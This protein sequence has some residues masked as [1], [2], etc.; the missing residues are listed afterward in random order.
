MT[1]VQTCALPIS[2]VVACLKRVLAHVH[3][4]Q[5]AL[6][7]VNLKALLPPATIAF[8]RAELFAI[9]EEIL[10]LMGEFRGRDQ[11]AS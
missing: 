5:A 6:E 1:G 9:R 7:Q 11:E 10:R 4:G 2:L 8:V 3:T